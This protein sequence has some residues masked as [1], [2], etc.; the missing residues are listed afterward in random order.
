VRDESARSRRSSGKLEVILVEVKRFDL[1]ASGL[2]L[3]K[4][5]A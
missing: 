5:V 1:R 2:S 4:T 3:R